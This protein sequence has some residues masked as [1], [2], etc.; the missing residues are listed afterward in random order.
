M[1]LFATIL[2]VACM[3]WEGLCA[4]VRGADVPDP[5]AM[6]FRLEMRKGSGDKPLVV[7]WI[8]D[9]DRQFVQTVRWFG[10]RRKYY[11]ALT[12]WALRSAK[13]KEGRAE[14][15]GVTS[16][17]LRWGGSGEFS[18]PLR[19]AK[20]DLTKGGYRVRIESRRDKG[21]HY[22]RFLIP[23]AAGFTGGE[24]EDKGYVKKVTI[25]VAGKQL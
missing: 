11:K 13:A 25:K 14:L 24:F 17:T 9:A 1:R 7:L 6:T 3:A 8:E 18:I 19:T 12:T 22:R 20:Y 2:V 16:A 15:D 23:I 21:G 10:K 5:A 4:Q